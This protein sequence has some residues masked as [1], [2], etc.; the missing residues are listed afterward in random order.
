M[1]TSSVNR[2]EVVSIQIHLH[3][4]QN[5]Y[6]LNILKWS[7]PAKKVIKKKLNWQGP[8]IIASSQGGVNI[9]EVAAENPEAIVY[10]PIDIN[11][12]ITAEQAERVAVKVGLEKQKESTVELLLNMYNLFI[13]KDA[14]LIEINPYAEDSNEKCT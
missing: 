2:H 6:L 7:L 5:A 13:S 9:E 4:S 14:L 1:S 11:M 8:V 12:G 10:E 3:H